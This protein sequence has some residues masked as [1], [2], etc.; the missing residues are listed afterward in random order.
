M[1]E[2]ELRAQYEESEGFTRF[3]EEYYYQFVYRRFHSLNRPKSITGSSNGNELFYYD[4]FDLPPIVFQRTRQ[5]CTFTCDRAKIDFPVNGVE[6]QWIPKHVPEDSALSDTRQITLHLHHSMPW[7]DHFLV[8]VNGTESI[9]REESC[10]VVLQSRENHI[11]VTPV[12]D[13]ERIGSTAVVSIW[14]N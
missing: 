7:F 6:I 3:W 11:S 9:V 5:T 10:D 2:S 4:A 8:V 13:C 1:K 14:V 12:N